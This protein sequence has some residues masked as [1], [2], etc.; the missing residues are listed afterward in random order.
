MLYE[1]IMK[2]EDTNYFLQIRSMGSTKVS[3]NFYSHSIF[4]IIQSHIPSVYIHICIYEFPQTVVEKTIY[5]I[6]SKS[7][8]AR[9]LS[10]VRFFVAL[11]TVACQVPV[12]MGFPRQ[13]YWNGLPFP[14]PG[15][16]PNPEI[17]SASPTLTG[18]FF[19]TEPPGKPHKS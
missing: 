9:M 14:S 11:W 17:K 7:N 8:S 18:G 2:S 3:N 10:Y 6:T 19:T 16:L 4:K 12:S 1:L 15:D 5:D 13:E